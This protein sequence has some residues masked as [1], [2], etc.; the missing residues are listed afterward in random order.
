MPVKTLFIS[1]PLFVVNGRKVEKNYADE[2][3]SLYHFSQLSL[4]ETAKY[5]PVSPLYNNSSKPIIVEVYVKYI[6]LV[7]TSLLKLDSI[8]LDPFWKI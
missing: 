4:I 7:Y 5:V 2:V 6:L 3:N 8:S 1:V